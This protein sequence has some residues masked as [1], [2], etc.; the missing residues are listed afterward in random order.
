MVRRTNFHLSPRRSG[1][2]SFY[3]RD[4][5]DNRIGFLLTDGSPLIKEN[6][7]IGNIQ[8]NHYIP[9]NRHSGF[10]MRMRIVVFEREILIGKL[11]NIFHLRIDFHRWQWPNVPA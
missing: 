7:F 9:S 1:A 2:A 4:Y 3:L 8:F 10:D 5:H 11:K 6:R